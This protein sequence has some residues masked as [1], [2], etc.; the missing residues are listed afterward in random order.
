M[1]IGI[2]ARPLS[3]LRAGIYRVVVNILQELERTEARNEYYLYSHRVL[4]LALPNSRWT[5]RGGAQRPL[6]P[7]S[8]W[9]Q[10]AARSMILR[11]RLDVFWGTAHLLPLGL[12]P[13]VGKV[14]SV[15]DLV[16]RLYPATVDRL[17]CNMHRLFAEKSIGRADRVVCCSERTGGD[18][19]KLLGVPRSRIQVISPGVLPDYWPR[20]PRSAA[21]YIARK[22][23]TGE[24]YV[25]TVG[26]IEPRKNL[27]TL[28]H[29]MKI[30]TERGGFS[31]QLLIAGGTGW[32]NS[33]IYATAHKLGLDEKAVK[34]LGYVPEEDLPLL[35]SGA[36]VFVFPSL[37]EGFGLPLIEAMAC[38]VPVVA[39][40]VSS[41]P[42]VV[43][44]AA[45]LVAPHGAEEF[46][47]AIC[48]VM[49]DESLRRALVERGI[50]R[51]RHFRY[52]V[53]ARKV[54]RV[55]EEAAAEARLR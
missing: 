23:G 50:Q 52:D 43:N 41:I 13:Q 26:T 29:A 54:L 35:Y 42:E 1:K 34:F 37:Y 24:D 4:D 21:Q 11:D 16:W 55:F 18:V 2:D 3:G 28:I 15:Y 14:V 49:G 46:A 44:D 51:A 20:E 40:N 17:N 19:E 10:T 32:R 8:L 27:I 9:F 7:G 39:S 5:R 25:C 45:M 30:L 31:S 36:R 12:P 38:G 47:D 53:A 22:F 48:H 6:L 33:D